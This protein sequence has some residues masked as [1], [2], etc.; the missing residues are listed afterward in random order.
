MTKALSEK[1]FGEKFDGLRQTWDSCLRGAEG[2]IRTILASANVEILDITSRIK[3][4]ESAYQK[5]IS[6][7]KNYADPFSQITD[8]IGIRV[9]VYLERDIQKVEEAIRSSLDVDAANS[10]D[11]TKELSIDRMG[12]RSKHLICSLGAS[13][14]ILPEYGIAAS[15]RFEV[16]IRS[17]LQHTWAEIEHRKRYKSLHSLP[18]DLQR[19]LNIISG[20]LELLDREFSDIV[21]KVEEYQEAVRESKSSLQNDPLTEIAATQLLIDRLG[22][23]KGST[24]EDFRYDWYRDVAI[25]E[26]KKFGIETIEDFENLLK[27]DRVLQSQS[28]IVGSRGQ[29][30]IGTVRDIMMIA[31]LR[32]YFEDAY[33]GNYILM[34]SE[35]E[36]LEDIYGAEETRKILDD[37]GV[38]VLGD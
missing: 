36:Y 6:K 21:S 25:G 37:A 35:A 13:R 32:K 16:Q 12:Y 17:A 28:Y 38:Q 9:T 5:Y 23:G 4:V 18:D 15:Q 3:T 22:V 29:T 27:N 20:T 11:K 10:I 2:I 33:P 14:E 31:D 24:K 8:F 34:E 26:L 7:S 1:E 19:R 30:F